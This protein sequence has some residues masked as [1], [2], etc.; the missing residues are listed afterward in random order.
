M[1]GSLKWFQY[2]T[3]TGVD[4]GVFMDESNGEAVGNTDWTASSAGLFK[5]PKNV[6]PRYAR[7]V[8]A[9]GTRAANIIV[10]DNTASVTTLPS[11]IDFDVAGRAAPVQLTLSEFVGERIRLIPRADDTGLND[12]DDT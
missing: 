9:D 1:A 4:F 12:G 8:S 2:T 11:T 10:T 6:K 7:Y 3:D 5:L